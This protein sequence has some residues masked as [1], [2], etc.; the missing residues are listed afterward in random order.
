MFII[1]PKQGEFNERLS[2]LNGQLES[3]EIKQKAYDEEL[4]RLIGLA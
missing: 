4:E 1:I 3:G 2:K